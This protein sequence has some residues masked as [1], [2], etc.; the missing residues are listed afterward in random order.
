MAKPGEN[1]SFV[2]NEDGLRVQKTATSTGV[3]KY[4]LHGKNIVHLSNGNDELHFFY[5]AQGRVAVV[6]YNGTPYRYV[7]NLHGDVIALVDST[8]VQVVEYWYDAWGKPTEKTG[9]MAETLGT[10][11][12]FRY[13]GYV[14]DEETRLLYLRSRYYWADWCRFCSCDFLSFNVGNLYA[15]CYSDPILFADPSGNIPQEEWASI[16]YNTMYMTTTSTMGLA[17]DHS[18]APIEV[19]RGTEIRVFLDG[20]GNLCGSLWCYGKGAIQDWVELQVQIV[21]NSCITENFTEAFFG[22]HGIDHYYNYESKDVWKVLEG[23]E[24]YTRA[25][26]NWEYSWPVKL[27]RSG[28][29]TDQAIKYIQN[30]IGVKADGKAGKDTLCALGEY[31]K[32]IEPYRY[33]MPS[34]RLTEYPHNMGR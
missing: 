32:R 11:Q 7:H 26:T 14:W 33:G 15:Y 22:M 23:I 30:E 16:K 28:N 9:S 21:D 12:P 6:D 25:K 3:T 27:P 4:T 31:V 20:E 2:Y 13:R 10:L 1:V 19:L 8:G 5:D 18:Y 24:L 34:H 17:Y 29:A